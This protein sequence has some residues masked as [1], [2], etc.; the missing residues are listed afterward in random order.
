MFLLVINDNLVNVSLDCMVQKQAQIFFKE[1]NDCLT[2]ALV[3]G[4]V[5]IKASNFVTSGNG[6]LKFEAFSS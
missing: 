1:Q 4:M 2:A 6:I 3:V 5:N